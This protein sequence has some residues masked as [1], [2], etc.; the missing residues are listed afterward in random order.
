LRVFPQLGYAGGDLYLVWT[1]VD[2]GSREMKA[3]RVP[4]ATSAGEL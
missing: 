4:V 2:D 3:V 1:D